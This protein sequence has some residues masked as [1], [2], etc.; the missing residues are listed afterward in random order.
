MRLANHP[1]SRQ[2]DELIAELADI[3]HLG[4]PPRIVPLNAQKSGKDKHLCPFWPASAPDGA[5][6]CPD[7]GVESG[8]SGKSPRGPRK[9]R[10]AAPACFPAI[11]HQPGGFASEPA[12]LDRSPPDRIAPRLGRLAADLTKR[13][14]EAAHGANTHLVPHSTRV[15]PP[16]RPA[17]ASVRCCGLIGLVRCRENPASRLRVMSSS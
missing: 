1:K 5:R 17:M 2:E 15:P 9:S 4:P 12:A 11:E 7:G 13:L 14:I 6:V 3:S 16:T 8:K 10:Q